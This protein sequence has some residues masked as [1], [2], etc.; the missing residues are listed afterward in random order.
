M[1]SPR[2]SVLVRVAVVAAT[3]AVVIVTTPDRAAARQLLQWQDVYPTSLAAENLVKAGASGCQLCHIASNGNEP[4]NSY[5]WALRQEYFANGEDIV[6][7][8]MAIEDVDHDMDPTGCSSLAEINADT[9]PGWTAGPNNTAHFEDGS[10]QKNQQPPGGGLVP[11]DPASPCCPADLDGNGTVDTTDFLAL[12][13]AWGTCP[14]PP[15]QCPADLDGNG[16]VD[17][18]DFLELLAS[19]GPC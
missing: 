15:M 13:A 11:L 10:V 3:M 8:I 6:A 17:T 5:G 12:L 1:K 14:D 4:W 7:A 2:T 16:E 9:Q 19:W 18:V